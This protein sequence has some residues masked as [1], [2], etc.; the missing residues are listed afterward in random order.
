M[1]ANYNTKN[2]ILNLNS[3]LRIKRSSLCTKIYCNTIC[4]TIVKIQ[5]DAKLDYNCKCF[6]FFFFSLYIKVVS[7]ENK[8]KTNQQSV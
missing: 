1:S 7:Y 8:R 5:C 2:Y 4:I 3:L 6:F